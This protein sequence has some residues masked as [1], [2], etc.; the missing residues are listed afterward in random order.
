[1]TLICLPVYKKSI[2]K[3]LEFV[4]R[5]KEIRQ[6][7]LSVYDIADVIELR[8]DWLANTNPNFALD[9]FKERIKKPKIATNRKPSEGGENPS[10]EEYERLN[11]LS[12]AVQLGYDYIDIEE[13]C[14]EG[15]IK[16]VA[17]DR[18]DSKII[19][20]KHDFKKTPDKLI[21]MANGFYDEYSPDILK[22]A[23]QYKKQED[24][25]EMQ[26]L[27]HVSPCDI[28]GIVMGEKGQATRLNRRNYLNFFS[29]D[30]KPKFGQ[31]NIFE[32]YRILKG[33]L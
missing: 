24:V 15:F 5:I 33:R 1:M 10:A 31:V 4:E 26:E 21:D 32:A 20:S 30:E 9:V 2:D 28:I 29:I 6:G 17:G 3:V 16:T 12:Y 25:E 14:D 19:L 22:F 27:I 11:S 8:L 13:S 7:G 18:R 23:T